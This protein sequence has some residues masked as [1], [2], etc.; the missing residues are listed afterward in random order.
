MAESSSLTTISRFYFRP[1]S[2]LQPPAAEE[3][4]ERFKET[5]ELPSI[6]SARNRRKEM[7]RRVA[8]TLHHRT[9]TR[10]E[11]VGMQLW[12]SAFLLADF[13]LHTT[14]STIITKNSHNRH[15]DYS[16]AA[17]VE[18]GAGIGLIASIASFLHCKAFV[19][20]DYKEDILV[21]A[22][23]NMLLNEHLPL[24]CG[25]NPSK[26]PVHFEIFDWRNPQTF[27]TAHL[28]S[29]SPLTS[30][31]RVFIAADVIYDDEITSALFQSLSLIMTTRDSF[32]IALEKRYN[33][34]VESLSLTPHGYATFR[35]FFREID[36]CYWLSV[37][38]S[39][40][41]PGGTL[42]GFV[43]R[44]IDLDAIPIYFEGYE[45]SKDMELWELRLI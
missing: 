22:R 36:S 6:S 43:G 33:F 40:E 23:R 9:S 17:L 2:D 7:E 41:V 35:S 20:T 32:L 4:E 30:V 45:R 8:L 39:N 31:L 29:S 21:L 38:L 34:E 16:G 12:P 11:D 27:M 25:R 13:L 37:P 1:P 26:V 10:L 24:S 28:A 14:A 42:T 18:L 5:D 19:C 44:R 3:A 15:C